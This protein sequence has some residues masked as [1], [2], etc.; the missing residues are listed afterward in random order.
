M[1]AR[2]GI[3][4]LAAQTGRSVHAI[5]WYEMQGLLPGVAR[6][7]GG[8]RAYDPQHVQW[9]ELMDRLRQTGMSIAEMRRY[10][11][12]VTQGRSTVAERARLL[13]VHRARVVQTVA[14]WKRAL[15]LIDRKIE[16]YGEW[17]ETGRRPRQLPSAPAKRAGKSGRGLGTA[18][19]GRPEL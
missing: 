1:S 14:R 5:R 19:T 6:D 4:W 11:V 16:F 3:G 7:S 9:L 13:E 2:L 18:G 15:A 12:M 10:T 17:E 8:R